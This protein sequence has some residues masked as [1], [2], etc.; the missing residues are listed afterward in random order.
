MM[1]DTSTATEIQVSFM[2]SAPDAIRTFDLMA[3][4]VLLRYLASRYLVAIDAM[5]TMMVGMEYSTSSLDMTF[6]IEEII[7]SI[8][9]A[10]MMREIIIVVVRSILARLSENFLW[11]ANFSLIIMR[12]PETE[13]VRLCMAS[14]AIA[15]EFDMN[16]T[17]RLKIASRKFIKINRYP[18]FKTFLLRS[19]S[20]VLF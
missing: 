9:I 18:A 2:V 16:P 13:S 7:I 8:P 4:P 5:R 3:L 19:F 20:I 10:M 15:R 11:A 12:N 17:I 1:A 14:V 6:L